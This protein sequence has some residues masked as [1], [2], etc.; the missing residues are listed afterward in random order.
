M[1]AHTA[2]STADRTIV[3]AA[4]ALLV[5]LVLSLGFA[6]PAAAQYGG[7]S[8]LFVSISADRPGF[9]DFTGLGC[10]GGSRVVL[11]M[12]GIQPTSSDP[13]SPVSVPGRILRVTRAESSDDPLVDGTFV[14]PRVRIPP[15][16]EPGVYAVHARCG[17]L[18]MRVHIE[19]SESGSITVTTGT[20]EDVL[21]PIEDI[22]GA[23]PFTGGTPSRLLALAGAL[24]AAG[25]GFMAVARRRYA[26][27]LG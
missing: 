1:S 9:A 7:I 14:F 20:P 27:P 2:A 3:T 26:Q 8:G 21:N 11:Y 19:L 23:L 25:V 24:L 16:L 6:A 10:E 18:D 5:S 22:P 13:A 4:R 15:T 12:P 17:D